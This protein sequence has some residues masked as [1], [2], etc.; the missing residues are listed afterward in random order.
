[1]SRSRPRNDVVT[2]SSTGRVATSIPCRDLLSVPPKQPRSRPQTGSRHR[3]SCPARARSRHQNQVATLLGTNLCRDI[4]FM[5][6][7]RFHV[8]TSFLPPM[9]FPSRDAKLQVATSHTAT[10]V[11]TSKMMS[12]PQLSSAPFLLRRDAIFPCHDLPCY[13]PCRDLKMMPRHQISFSPTVLRRDAIFPCC[14]LPCYHPC[15][16]LKMMSRHQS[17]LAK[18]PGRPS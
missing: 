17:Q 13:H 8:A 2:P 3:F 15:R 18:I 16:D 6:R 11:V 7:H 5:S 1:M 10:H 12:Q 4:A 9:G 14:D